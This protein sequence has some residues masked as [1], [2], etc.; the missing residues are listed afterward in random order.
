M[1]KLTISKICKMLKIILPLRG[2]KMNEKRRLYIILSTII[3]LF[4]TIVPT[5]F[6]I[7][8]SY[9]TIRVRISMKD[10]APKTI[11]VVL[12]GA[13]YLAENPDINLPE[14]EYAVS[15]I[16]TNKVKI[17]GNGVA[18]T[19]GTSLTFIRQKYSGT[20]D[21][22]LRINNTLYGSINYLGDMKFN[23]SSGKLVVTNHVPLE[24]YLYGVV[25]HEMSNSFPLEALK[26]QAVSARSYA[27]KSFSTSRD[28]DI[29]DTPASQVYKGYNPNYTNV[30]KA[31]NETK[32]QV[33]TYNGNI[34]STY[35]S[36]SNGGQTELPGNTWGGG[37]AKNNAYPYLAQ[38]DDP[39]DTRNP[40]SLYQ[41]VFVPKAVD[42]TKYVAAESN[43]DGEFVVRIVGVTTAANIRSGPGTNHSIVGTAPLNAI[44]KWIST[45]TTKDSAGYLWHKINFTGNEDDP[46][47]I[48]ED[49]GQKI[50][51]G[52]FVYSNPI[53][54]DIQSQ[55]FE[56]IKDSKNINK[57]TDI[58]INSVNTFANG[59]ERWPGT[60]SRSYVTANAGVTVQYYAEGS[61]SLSSK[62]NENVVVELMKTNSNGS[63]LMGH[64]Y[65]NS[66]LRLRGVK[67]AK[68]S[69]GLDG[70]AITNAR[71]GHGVGMSQRGAQQMAKEGKTYKEIL[72][73]YF[74]KTQIKTYDTTVPE[75]PSRGDS[76]DTTQP[77]PTISSSKHKLQSNSVT[78]IAEKTSVSAFLGN[79]SVNNGSLSLVAADKKAKTSGNVGTGDVLYLKDGSGK[80]VK[81]YSVVIY[82]DVNGDGEISI[83]DLLRV[84]RHL[85]DVSKVQGIYSSAADVSKD[86]K[87]T[88]A[89]LLRIQRHLLNVSKITQ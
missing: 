19:I 59:K 50:E 54:T 56:K 20:G 35:Y 62:I 17:K 7:E 89:D 53:L 39:Y 18:K 52:R 51:N 49:L 82:G 23:V 66:N 78:G 71:Y 24:Q 2:M 13:Y 64:P 34:I 86:G 22:H 41:E 40:S 47:Y 8:T 16:D 27:I 76:T 60:G 88:I 58:K 31:V 10:D 43:I 73:F 63:Y 28:Y 21:H 36:A 84:Q 26:A 57:P 87:V 69:S 55:V 6:A 77:A 14:G 15:I 48:R 33:V 4:A 72:A 44:Y 37:T 68:D 11:N 70:Y 65:L 3:F 25:A 38:K 85:L 12:S 79:F 74:D 5:I 1:M 29:G 30:I 67:A 9:K 61:S 75:L 81:S 32:G 80:T 83:M 45:T 42:G 46:A